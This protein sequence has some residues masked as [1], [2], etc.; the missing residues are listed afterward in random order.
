MQ[1][2]S[3]GR[4]SWIGSLRKDDVMK[5][6]DVSIN[7][8]ADNLGR[9]DESMRSAVDDLKEQVTQVRD[10]EP[11]SRDQVAQ[12]RRKIGELENALTFF[13]RD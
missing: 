7:N 6:L 1:D 11:L 12:I 3:E 5:G 8:L 2:L 4:I 9:L 13:K 10:D